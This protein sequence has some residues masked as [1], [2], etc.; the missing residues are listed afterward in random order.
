MVERAVRT[1]IPIMESPFKEIFL[2]SG[3]LKKTMNP[4]KRIK[5]SPINIK[6]APT[7]APNIPVQR[8]KRFPWDR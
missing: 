5:N 6:L 4:E 2:A 8:P 1:P 7:K 3:F